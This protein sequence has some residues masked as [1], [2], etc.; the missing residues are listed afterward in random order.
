MNN[1]AIEE[2]R[3]IETNGW[4]QFYKGKIYGNRITPIHCR[5]YN[6]TVIDREGEGLK[7]KQLA[8]P[9]GVTM[10]TRKIRAEILEEVTR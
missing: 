4:F 8:F 5:I 10:D 2:G 1:K 9:N 7:V 3:K 6:K